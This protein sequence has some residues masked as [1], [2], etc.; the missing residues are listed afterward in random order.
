[1]SSGWSLYI[2]VLTLGTLA[3]LTWL[4]LATR[5]GERKE[6]GEQTTGHVYDGIEEYDNP[7]PA[8]WFKLFIATIVFSLGYLLLYPGLGNW[9][10]LLPGY[11]WLDAGSQTRFADGQQG[12]SAVHEWEKE[13]ARSD[14]QYAP[15]FA[16]FAAMPV[17]AV[18]RDAEALQMGARLFAANCSVCHGAD[19]K[20]AYGFPNLTDEHWRWGGDAQ[21]IK[22]SILNGRRAVMPGWG[23]V[24]GEQGVNDVAAWLLTRLGR[25]L[26][27]GLTLDPVAGQQRYA[28]TCIACHGAEGKGN[29]LLGAPDLTQ[30]GAYVYGTGFAQLQESIAKGRMGQMPAQK[31]IQGDDR[32]HVLAG[33]I[34]SLSRQDK[35]VEVP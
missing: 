7:L 31:A 30:P 10:G 14:A 11:A 18:A 6:P 21:S 32:V 16:R 9:R 34:Y 23:P 5:K 26:P 20:G 25:P 17:E 12:W 33:Y 29:P 4:L 24:L 15:I 3:G 22:T 2:T 28:T 13:M 19:A 8:W 35:T 27:E 1:M